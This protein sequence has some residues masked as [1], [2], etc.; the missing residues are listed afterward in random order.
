MSTVRRV[1]KNSGVMMA[2]TL[3]EALIKLVAIVYLARY[4]GSVGYGKYTFALSFVA[5]LGVLADLDIDRILVREISVNKARAS[6]IL[7]NALVMRSILVL[8]AL[9]VIAIGINLLGYPPD[10]TMAVYIVSFT[11]VFTTLGNTLATIFTVHLKMEYQVFANVLAKLVYALLIFWIAFNGGGLLDFVAAM[12]FSFAVN[13]FTVFLL[14][15]SF[16]LP[17]LELDISLWKEILT[18]SAPLAASA[19]FITIY[20]KI[21]VVLLSLFQGDAAVGLFSAANALISNL[22]IIPYALAL[23]LFP[24][25]SSYFKS[26][27]AAFIKTYKMGFKLVLLIAV[28]IAVGTSILSDQI[29]ALIYGEKYLASAHIL[30]L[31]IWMGT[32]SFMNILFNFSIISMNKQWVIVRVVALMAFINVALNF[33]LVPTYSYIGTSIAA[34]VT[35]AC[36]TVIFFYIMYKFTNQAFGWTILKIGIANLVLLAF[37]LK[38]STVSIWVI[39]PLS[40]LLYLALLLILKII[41]EEEFSLIRKLFGTVESPAALKTTDRYPPSL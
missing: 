5:L 33:L 16:V 29:I 7:G 36:G 27:M 35:E 21:N 12:V 32:F 10:T 4:L 9:A 41:S 15:R 14:S 8:V 24:L 1:A 20:T 39:G 2:G 6:K 19:V 13:F 40:A 25:M 23:S 38:F 17:K 30:S 18:Y 37:L 31:L 11:L 34:I 26:S 28:P 3:A 22:A